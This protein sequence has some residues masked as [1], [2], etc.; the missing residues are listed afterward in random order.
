M[1]LL[2]HIQ[3]HIQSYS[4]LCVQ[5]SL[6]IFQ[7]PTCFDPPASKPINLI[8]KQNLNK[9]KVTSSHLN[10]KEALLSI[11]RTPPRAI[12]IHKHTHTVD[13]LPKNLILFPCV[14]IRDVIL[15]ASV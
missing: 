10:M 8:R 6:S 1:V 14:R 9:Q 11:S 5:N 15:I 12:N 3:N 7:R 13:N 4:L 2:L